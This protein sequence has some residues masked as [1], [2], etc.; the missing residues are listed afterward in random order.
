[1]ENRV[2][3][4]LEQAEQT[5]ASLAKI[6]DISSREAAD[7][8]IGAPRFWE[9]LKNALIQ[10]RDALNATPDI[11][12]R[13]SLI[14]QEVT[15]ENG[16]GIERDY[17][18][19]IGVVLIYS[20]D[21]LKHHTITYR[22]HLRENGARNEYPSKWSARILVAED[23]EPYLP[24]GGT[25]RQLAAGDVATVLLGPLVSGRVRDIHNRQA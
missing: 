25:G 6:R 21:H 4:L 13:V 19:R 23:G 8:E 18:P 7:L 24:E 20:V 2:K 11:T 14:D 22:Y 17:A 3:A 9:S 12:K 15:G 1:M 10:G 5:D 16:F